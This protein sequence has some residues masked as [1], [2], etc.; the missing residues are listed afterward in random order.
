MP[1]RYVRF[2]AVLLIGCAPLVTAQAQAAQDLTLEAPDGT[3]VT[4]DRDDFGVPHITAETEAAVF[5]GQGFAVA[6]DRLFQMETFWRS[7]TGRLSELIGAAGVGADQQARTLF[8]TPAERQTQFEALPDRIQTMMLGFRDG[9]NAYIDSTVAN[10]DVYLP[11]EYTQFPLSALGAEPWDTDK[12]VAVT[13][14]FIRRFGEAG[15]AELDRLAEL[16]AN[17]QAWFDENRP[18]NDPTAP[19]TIPAGTAALPAPAT[20]TYRGPSVDPALHE[21]VAARREAVER[22]YDEIGVPR[23]FGSYAALIGGSQSVSGDVMLLGAPQMGVP[24]VTGPGATGRAVTWESELLVGSVDDPELHVAGM[25]VPGIPGIIIG[26]TADRAWTLTSG[27]SDNVD[28]F[29]ETTEDNTLS[30]YLYDGSFVDYDVITET[31]NVLGGAPIE[32]TH[33]R[34][35]H[36][37]VYAT[38]LDNQQAFTWQYTFWSRELDMATAFYDI[39]KAESV[40]EAEAALEIVP[41]SFNFFHADKDQNIN[42]WHVGRY[43]DRPDGA[44]PRLPLLGDGSQEWDGILD[45]GSLPQD[46]NPAQGYYVNWNNKPAVWWDHGDIMPWAPAGGRS[47]DGVLDIEEF[48]TQEV[49]LAFDE[50]KGIH[51]VIDAREYPGTYQQLLQFAENGS[52]AE[53]MVPPGQSAF[54]NSVGQPSPHIAD[55]WPLYQTYEMKPFLFL[56]A[57]PVANETGATP[58]ETPSLGVLYPNPLTADGLTVRF[59][60]PESGTAR[61]EVIDVLGRTVAVLADGPQAAGSQSAAFD[62]SGLPSG[63]YFVRLTADGTTQARKLTVVR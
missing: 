37:P 34:S 8:Y 51:A 12:L 31:I 42:F 15:G 3:T 17:G 44:D 46:A 47:Y 33:H 10:P 32:F 55:Q 61:I 29:V 54:F 63:V 35:V 22:L 38:D 60:M 14:F 40:G 43:P 7:S 62:A 19:T 6:Q 41:V 59:E 48:V 56:G 30:R 45:F 1:N 50:M 13:Q 27:V 49:P 52:R 4:I 25:T 24:S 36:G 9:V 57:N 11:V 21:A 20:V 26:R 5:F 28:T 18:I 2:L 58:G 16:E 53:N 23:K 39:W